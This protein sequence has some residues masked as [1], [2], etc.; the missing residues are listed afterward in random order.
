VQSRKE[1]STWKCLKVCRKECEQEFSERL[2]V[3]GNIKRILTFKGAEERREVKYLET[4]K[5]G[6]VKSTVG[7]Q[8]LWRG[9]LC[10]EVAEVLEKEREERMIEILYGEFVK[11]L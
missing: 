5:E 2:E 9:T 10:L 7:E 1:F 11:S 4:L 8:V 6:V 3:M